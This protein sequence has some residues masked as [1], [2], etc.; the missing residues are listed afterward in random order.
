MILVGF[1]VTNC[2]INNPCE[3]GD[4]W[5][6]GW[7]WDD[8]GCGDDPD[9]D[10]PDPYECP[11]TNSINDI[12]AYK[13]E[14]DVMLDWNV[15]LV[16]QDGKGYY[17]ND[18]GEFIGD[19][20]FIVT[21]S[22]G[23]QYYSAENTKPV[24]FQNLELTTWT[25]TVQ[26]YNWYNECLL[27]EGSTTFTLDG[28]TGGGGDEDICDIWSAITCGTA[29]ATVDGDSATIDWSGCLPDSGLYDSYSVSV[30]DGNGEYRSL[31]NQKP[32]SF[33]DLPSGTYTVTV[34][35]YKEPCEP[36]SITTTFEIEKTCDEWDNYDVGTVYAGLSTNQD[37]YIDWAG[38]TVIDQDYFEVTLVGGSKTFTPIVDTKPAYFDGLE[39]D[40]NYV[41]TVTYYNAACTSKSGYISFELDE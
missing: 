33:S 20:Y 11:T 21:I 3:D 9:P 14:H 7:S 24:L 19:Y 38:G 32:A 10:E 25:V 36:K 40:T 31:D 18:S 29:A 23:S 28:S 16:S 17:Y 1:S 27:A 2:E 15:S 6:W 4:D 8:D 26:Y 13:A 35:Y 22:A 12:T 41:A 37:V 30:D 34:T 5:G 39:L